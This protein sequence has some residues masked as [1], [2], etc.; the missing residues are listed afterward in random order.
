M[1][2]V[3]YFMIKKIGLFS[4]AAQRDEKIFPELIKVK[5]EYELEVLFLMKKCKLEGEEEVINLI[6]SLL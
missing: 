1:K 2:I 4:E 5:E 6:V 3:S